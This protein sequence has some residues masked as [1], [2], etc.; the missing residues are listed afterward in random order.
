MKFSEISSF[1]K[2]Y[3][4]QYISSWRQSIAIGVKFSNNKKHH[5]QPTRRDVRYKIDFQK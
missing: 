1:I 2:N 5:A 3:Q 4:V